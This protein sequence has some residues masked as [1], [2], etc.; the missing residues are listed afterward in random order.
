MVH[1]HNSFFK[2]KKKQGKLSFRSHFFSHLWNCTLVQPF[3]ALKI[4]L[5]YVQGC[6]KRKLKY[7]PTNWI[8]ISSEKLNFINLNRQPSIE[9]AIEPRA[10]AA[11]KH[12]QMLAVEFQNP[13]L[14]HLIL[15]QTC[16]ALTLELET[17]FLEA[18][19]SSQIYTNYK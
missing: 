17:L 13:A 14:S 1:K 3:T 9:L 18:L 12:R 8:E 10:L 7:T 11:F 2:R 5:I 15:G 16:M 6:E 19:N 4:I